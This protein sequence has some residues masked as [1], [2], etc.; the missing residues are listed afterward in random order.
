MSARLAAYR[1]LVEQ[2]RAARDRGDDG[3]AMVLERQMGVEYDALDQQER[4]VLSMA[5]KRRR[6]R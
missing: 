5:A 6:G 3:E 1:R 2:R 4:A